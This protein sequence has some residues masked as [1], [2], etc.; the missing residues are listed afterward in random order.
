MR[1]ATILI[2]AFKFK[3][4][5]LIGIIIYILFLFKTIYFV[6]CP[7]PYG[8]RTNQIINNEH[9]NYSNSEKYSS[10]S[11]FHKFDFNNT[12]NPK[13]VFNFPSVLSNFKHFQ[14]K[15]NKLQP[16]F[17]LSKHRNSK[18]VIGV[19]TVERRNNYFD[20]MLKSVIETMNDFEKNQTL[21]VILISEVIFHIIITVNA[22][23]QRQILDQA[24]RI[25]Y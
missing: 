22:C 10:K 7:L 4:I 13:Y 19:P 14:K 8:N 2:Y 6:K 9:H 24:L 11:I 16:R 18:F 1:L 17:L 5:C 21:I 25:N 12:I 20:I 15:S 23:R 3:K